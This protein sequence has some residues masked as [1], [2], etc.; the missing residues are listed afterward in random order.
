MA[1]LPEKQSALAPADAAPTPAGAQESSPS[2]YSP[3]METPDG[4]ED[5][6]M[7]YFGESTRGD[8]LPTP[9]YLSDESAQLSPEEA[10][11]I[12]NDLGLDKWGT[13]TTWGLP[14]EPQ[15]AVFC[16]RTINLRSIRVIGYDMDYTLI[17]YKVVAWEGR[18]YHYAKENLREVGVQ[19]VRI[20]A[21]VCGREVVHTHT[22]THTHTHKHMV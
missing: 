9:S 16:S 19:L 13:P 21:C 6:P 4:T 1:D 2:F 10:T 17:H 18:A 8:I 5:W 3:I 12:C 22:H 15:R 7:D 14:A 20:P 11:G